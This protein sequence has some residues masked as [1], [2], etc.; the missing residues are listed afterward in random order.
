MKGAI[1]FSYNARIAQKSMMVAAAP[2]V[3]LFFNCLKKNENFYARGLI[4]EGWFLTNRD[5]G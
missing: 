1:Y 4:K 2:I 5:I 3:K